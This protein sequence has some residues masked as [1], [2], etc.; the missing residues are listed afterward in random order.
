MKV[1]VIFLIFSISILAHAKECTNT[2]AGLKTFTGH[3]DVSMDWL[4]HSTSTPLTL[5]L[6]EKDNL[7]FFKLTNSKGVWAEVL[8]KF[9]KDG[10]RSFIAKTSDFKWG[11]EAPSLARMKTIK[12]ISIDL[13]NKENLKVSVAFFSFDFKPL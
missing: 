1:I 4:E 8:G 10:D 3:P 2:L 9:C 6:T 5:K 13:P 11:P 7:I 12:E